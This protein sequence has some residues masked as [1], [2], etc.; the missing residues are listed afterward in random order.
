VLNHLHSQGFFQP[1]L[2]FTESELLAIEQGLADSG[3]L[4]GRS[5]GVRRILKKVQTLQRLV[6]TPQLKELC[7]SFGSGFQC[8]KSL[9]FN[10]PERSNWIVPWHQDLFINVR[11]KAE[12][13]GFRQWQKRVGYCSVQPPLSILENTITLRIH[14]DDSNRTS[15][16]MKVLPRTH[17]DGIRDLSA[18][19]ERETEEAVLPTLKRGDLLVSK[20]LLLHASGK[21]QSPRPRR[22]LHLEFCALPLPP[23]LVWEEAYRL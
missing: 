12:V 23:P 2:R 19:S 7:G 9:Y 17:L 8:V 5:H 6:F 10:K 3:L 14:L 4:S 13:P 20:P 1:D 22:V 15:G 16:G 18:L 21:S 11:E